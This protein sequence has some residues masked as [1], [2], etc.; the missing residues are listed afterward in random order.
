MVELED[1]TKAEL[2]NA[3]YAFW[4]DLRN[5]KEQI[6]TLRNRLKN[7]EATERTLNE[8]IRSLNEEAAKVVAEG[9]INVVKQE[10]TPWIQEVAGQVEACGIQIEEIIEHYDSLRECLE[11]LR[12]EE[13]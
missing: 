2:L 4:T 12:G 7:F 1:M 6:T 11:R 5:K 8:T 3:A 9:R 13:S 10:R